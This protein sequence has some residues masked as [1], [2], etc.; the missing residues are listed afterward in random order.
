[1][2]GRKPSLGSRHQGIYSPKLGRLVVVGL[3]GIALLALLG[4]IG[5][6]T[7]SFVK[8]A[9]GG[10]ALPGEQVQLRLDRPLVEIPIPPSPEEAEITSPQTADLNEETAKQLIELWLT[11]KAEAFGPEHKVQALET[12]LVEPELTKRTQWAQGNEREGVYTEYSHRI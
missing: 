2:T 3:A 11:A 9:V 10:G 12:I 6:W 7:L 8:R 1:M 4:L 5:N